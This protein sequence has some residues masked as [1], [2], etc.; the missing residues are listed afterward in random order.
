LHPASAVNPL[1][2]NFHRLTI[3]LTYRTLAKEHGIPRHVDQEAA[4]SRSG[5]T[6]QRD[7]LA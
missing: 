5:P 1:I 4:T 6:R 3:L 7:A 2:E